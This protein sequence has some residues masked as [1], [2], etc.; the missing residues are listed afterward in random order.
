MVNSVSVSVVIPTYRD[1]E[2]TIALARSLAAH[3]PS[4]GATLEIL[5]VDDGSGDGSAERIADALGDTIVLQS[6]PANR[7]RAIARNEGAIGASGERLL[8]LDC[9][10]LPADDGLVAAHLRAW[11]PGTV[12]SIGPVTGHGGG[13]WDR[14]QRDASARRAR[15]HAAGSHFSGSSQNLMVS[16]DAFRA[17]GGFDPRY[18]TYGFEDRDLQLRLGRLGRIAW[19]HAAVVRHMDDLSLRGV[20]AKMAEAGGASAVRFAG[21]HPEA[22]EALGYAALD[23]RRRRWLLP[24]ARLVDR[25]LPSLAIALEPVLHAP[26]P[27]ALL[28][29]LVKSLTALAYLGGTSRGGAP[30]ARGHNT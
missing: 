15:Q 22:Y 26:L 7:G 27:H 24:L 30:D 12:A 29:G 10:C 18:R 19:A 13:F 21:R 17:C 1:A 14:Y 2:R 25:G 16:R 9:D 11:T 23:V 6:L 3:R 5:V 20:C 4:Q 8:F 28:R